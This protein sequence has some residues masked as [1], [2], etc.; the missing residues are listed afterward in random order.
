[1]P[2][3]LVFRNGVSRRQP[4][5]GVVPLAGGPP[6]FGTKFSVIMPEMRRD[7]LARRLAREAD[8]M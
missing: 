8:A 2:S 7:L 1:M 5:I 6:F 4:A 3:R